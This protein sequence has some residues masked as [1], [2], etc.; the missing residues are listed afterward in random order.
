MFKRTTPGPAPD[1]SRTSDPNQQQL[2]GLNLD[3]LHALRTAQHTSTT[4]VR[5]ELRLPEAQATALAICSSEALARMASCG[6]SLFSLN[7]HRIDEWLHLARQSAVVSNSSGETTGSA[8]HTQD[9]LAMQVGNFMQCAVFFAWHLAQ[10]NPQAARL[11]L[12]MSEDTA[13]VLRGMN[14]GHCRHIAQRYTKLLSPRW[15]HNRFFWPDLLRY[16]VSGEAEHFRFAQLL[17]TQLV[18]QD[19]EPSAIARLSSIEPD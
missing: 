15:L 4:A 5:A 12:G 9:T 7:L 3:F 16:A 2:L 18:A 8:P 11:M 14:L 17:S 1:A 6:Y 19:L 10:Q 13:A